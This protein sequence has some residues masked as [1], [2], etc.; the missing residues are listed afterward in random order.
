MTTAPRLVAHQT[1]AR[2]VA[3]GLALV[4]T[5]GLM[6]GLDQVADRQYDNALMAQADEVPTQVVVITAKRLSA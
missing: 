3:A 4:L 6:A 1:A 5:L 2:R